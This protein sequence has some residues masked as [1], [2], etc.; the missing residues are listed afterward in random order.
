M[1]VANIEIE[2][3]PSGEHGEEIS[4]NM[5]QHIPFKHEE[6]GMVAESQFLSREQASVN[7]MV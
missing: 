4:P 1:L 3:S 5:W 7:A 6:A 2:M